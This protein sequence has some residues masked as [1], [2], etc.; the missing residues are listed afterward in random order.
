MKFSYID[1][2]LYGGLVIAAYFGYKG[3]FVKKIFNLLALIASIVIAVQF[4]EPVGSFLIGVGLLSE[5]AAYIVGFALVNI[6]L[7]V[8]AILLY[9]RFGQTAVAKSSSQLMGVILGVLEGAMIISLILLAL[10]M[11]DFP[12]KEAR[13]DSLLYKPL[14]NFAPKSFDLLRSYLP[15]ASSFQEELTKTFQKWNIFDTVSPPGKK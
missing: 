8:A 6:L 3:G 13:T 1:I 11:A 7:M 5:P 4:M 14:V 12:S 9:R 2:F 15:G 10:K